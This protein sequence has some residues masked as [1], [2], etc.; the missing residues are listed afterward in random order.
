[1]NLIVHFTDY[2]ETQREAWLAEEGNSFTLPEKMTSENFRRC[3]M[4][5]VRIYVIRRQNSLKETMGITGK[6]L[7]WLKNQSKESIVSVFF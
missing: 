2:Y 3:I 4:D 1:M 5:R 6:W 7:G